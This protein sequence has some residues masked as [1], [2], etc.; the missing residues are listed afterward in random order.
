MRNLITIVESA[1][2][3]SITNI[4]AKLGEAVIIHDRATSD[5]DGKMR[6]L[7]IHMNPGKQETEALLDRSLDGAIRGFV[8]DS[9]NDIGAVVIWDAYLT[10]H[11]GAEYLLKQH[12]Y[13]EWWP[14]FSVSRNGFKT[15]IVG[16]YLDHGMKEAD[17]DALPKKHLARM[18]GQEPTFDP[19]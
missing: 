19:Q 8:R 17:W 9:G 10:D 14:R 15:G 1:D 11:G 16:N 12:G 18:M 3:K 13:G 7:T 2:G 6:D 5:V 4:S